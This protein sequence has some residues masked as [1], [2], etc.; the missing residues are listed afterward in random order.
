MSGP[1]APPPLALDGSGLQVAIVA[2]RWHAEVADAL[3]DGAGRALARC[4]VTDQELV[5]VPGAFEL[6]PVAQALARQRY[7]AVIALA[8]VI[9]GGTPHFDYVCQAVTEGCARVAL[10]TGVAIGFGVLT[11]ENIEQAL[12]RCGLPTSTEDKG[13]DAALAAV[14]TALLLRRLGSASAR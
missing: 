7:D 4:T 13:G 11:C 5:R 9:R 14:E 10:D 2:A 8:V 12:A 6:P 3:V 1:G